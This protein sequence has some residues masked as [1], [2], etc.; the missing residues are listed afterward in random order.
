[1]EA[2]RALTMSGYQQLV[3]HAG[4]ITWDGGSKD[5]DEDDSKQD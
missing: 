1:M 4:L 3:S 2:E 5:D